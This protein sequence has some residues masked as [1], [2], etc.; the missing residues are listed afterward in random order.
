M[1]FSENDLLQIR[2]QRLEQQV[3]QLQDNMFRVFLK[4]TQTWNGAFYSPLYN[5]P[6]TTEG[7]K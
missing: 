6:P 1:V 2:V 4:G 5:S 3:K 7:K